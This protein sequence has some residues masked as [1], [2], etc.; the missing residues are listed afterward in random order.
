LYLKKSESSQKLVSFVIVALISIQ[1]AQRPVRPGVQPLRVF[2]R[3]LSMHPCQ[4]DNSW[5]SSRGWSW[6]P[7]PP[8]WPLTMVR[9]FN[10]ISFMLGTAKGPSIDSWIGSWQATF[11][12]GQRTKKAFEAFL[13]PYWKFFFVSFEKICHLSSN[14]SNK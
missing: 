5:H 13:Q 12:R 2:P 9:S 11:W 14:I 4:S 10:W 7:R 8:P 1:W 3:S 6:R